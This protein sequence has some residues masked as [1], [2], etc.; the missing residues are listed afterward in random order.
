M[1]FDDTEEDAEFRRAASAWL[2]AHADARTGLKDWSRNP[3]HP[4][5]VRRCREWQHTLSEGGWGAITWPVEYGGRGDSAWHQTIFNQETARY[6]VSVGVFSVGIGMAGPTL[7]AHGSEEQKQRYLPPM[8]RGEEV[9]CQLFSEPDAG[10]DLAALKTRAERDGEAFVVNGQKVWT[11]GAQY[12]DWGILI[13]RTNAEVPKHKGITYFVVDMRTPGVEVRPLRQ[14]TGI[15]HFNEVFLRDVAVPTANVVGEIDGGWAVAHTTMG[16]ER[17]LIG[18]TG[19]GFTIGQ[20]LDLARRCGKSTDPLI[21]QH[22]VDFFTRLE[23]LR[24]MN[25]RVQTAL[26]KGRLPG[27]EASTTKLFVSRHMSLTGELFMR[28]LGANGMLADGAALD[29]GIWETAF[30]NQWTSRLG[31]GTDNIQRNSLGE[32]VLGLPREPRAD[33]DQPFSAVREADARAPRVGAQELRGT[34]EPAQRKGT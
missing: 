34:G 2:E 25:Y 21:R 29:D 23:L 26:S 18:G 13:A 10:S 19:Q 7:I 9:W 3:A 15:A 30:L 24:Y 33:K 16:Y 31:G 28:L 4:D 14:I 6:D 5:Y 11:S 22:L 20:V 27:P 17:A 12:S 32:R 1:D 8:L